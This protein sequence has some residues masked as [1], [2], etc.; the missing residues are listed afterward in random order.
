MKSRASI[1]RA[2]TLVELLVV[3]AI[4]GILV[5]LLLPAIQA[6][7]EAARRSSCVNNL[8]Q[9]GLALHNYHSAHQLF[10]TGAIWQNTDVYVNANAM[11]LPYFEEAALQNLYDF[12][13][14]WEGQRADVTAAVIDVFDCPSTSED[15]PRFHPAL[16]GIVNNLLFGTTDY[17]FCK[18][19]TDAWCVR[20]GAG[21]GRV[22]GDMPWEVRG[23]FDMQWGAAIRHIQDGT[24]KTIAVGDASGSPDWTV[25]HLA[26]CT[27]P[28]LDR[29]GEPASAWMAW[30]IGEP[31]HTQ[32]YNAGLRATSIWAA[33]VEPMNKNPVTD[34]FVSIIHFWGNQCIDSRDGGTQSAS[35]FRSDHPGGC[36]F[37]FADGSVRFI[38][39]SI[40]M[41]TYQAQSTIAGGEIVSD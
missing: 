17:A 16:E 26:G 41:V 2:F 5:A 35:N 3:I 38:D 32:Y 10:P 33:T 9:Y 7:R 25:C 24:S 29:D 31:V 34:T 22:Y 18:G 8:K 13:R 30:I 39:E 14:P 15:N 4:I 11:L 20:N 36:N 19:A 1:H 40:D 37:A 21:G 23:V 27:E 6:A 28:E 12:S